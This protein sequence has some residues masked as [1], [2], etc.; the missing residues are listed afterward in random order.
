MMAASHA[1]RMFNHVVSN[2]RRKVAERACEA[3][4]LSL[5]AAEI[6]DFAW[7]TLCVLAHEDTREDWRGI[8]DRLIKA[9][10]SGD[11]DMLK[12]HPDL[13]RVAMTRSQSFSASSVSSVVEEPAHAG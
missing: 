6:D 13:R 7:G 1:R 4:H 8:L 3:L 2:F 10:L 12:V 9:V 11:Q 5:T